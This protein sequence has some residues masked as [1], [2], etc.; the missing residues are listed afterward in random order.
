MKI[1]TLLRRY[2]EAQ[3]YYLQQRNALPYGVDYMLDIKRL[4]AAWE[5]SVKSFFD[6]GAHWGETSKSGPDDIPGRLGFSL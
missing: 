1:R 3:G 2:L 6:V 4:C 5:L